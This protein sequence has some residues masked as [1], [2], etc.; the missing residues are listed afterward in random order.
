MKQMQFI[1][2]QSIPAV[3][4]AA[5]GVVLI[6]TSIAAP[7]LQ[8]EAPPAGPIAVI[9]Q[10][11]KMDVLPGRFALTGR[12]AIYVYENTRREGQYL[13]QRLAPAGLELD[14][15]TAE[16]GKDYPDGILL[17]IAGQSKALGPEGYML[18]VRRDRVLVEAAT[19][20][21]VFYG[22]QTILQLLPPAIESAKAV[23][24]VRWTIPQVRITDKPRFPWRGL[25]L[26][27]G[28]CYY[29][30]AWLK[31]YID[32]LAYYKM[33]RFHW[34]LTERVGWRIEIK[35]YP[36]LIRHGIH[37]TDADRKP[38]A[39]GKTS[40]EY[41]T[42]EEI[43]EIVAYAKSRHVMVIPEIE[44][45]G[46]CRLAVET[47]PKQL[48]CE[49]L[50]GRVPAHLVN[51]IF[52]AG[53]DSTFEF[54]DG[55]LGEVAELF[56]APWIHIGGDEP[57][58]NAWRICTKCQARIKAEG[59]K[60]THGLYNYFIKRVEKILASKGKRLYGWEEVGRAGLSS[61]GTIQSWHGIG[62]GLAA[63]KRG[64]DVVM[65]PSSHCY[66]DMSYGKV[67][68]ARSHSFEPMP[69]NLPADKA[70]HILGVEAPMWMDRWRN[71]AQYRPR[72]GTLGR[73]DYQVFPRLI[74]LAEVGWSAKER[75]QWA[76]FRKRLNAHG[77][78]LEMLGV[79][80]YRD[81]AVWEK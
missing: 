58:M 7:S 12:S 1:E 56:P 44:M 4:L 3:R 81:R 49:G 22:C 60:D 2:V 46:H 67:S 52:C 26:D 73:V 68:V 30:M 61:G 19:P 43:R 16:P 11:A 45:P 36:E 14:V 64:N 78:R 54:F 65:S 74:A 18:E 41:Y 79:S 5:V 9:P 6:L 37:T 23:A 20:A 71:W 66:L 29:R 42:Q 62:P 31:R 34:H 25:M 59:L 77:Q 27:T 28:R 80:Y 10:P 33:N 35:K 76:D 13:A 69:P 55:V 75:R 24:N 50:K 63:A 72:T 39:K 53:K 70:R 47:Y 57:I 21:G 17:R 38:L 40:R 51:R 8:A 15:K 48:A 32:L